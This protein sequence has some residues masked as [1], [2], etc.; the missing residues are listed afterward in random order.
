MNQ[1][2]PSVDQLFHDVTGPVKP[3]VFDQKVARVFDDMVARSI[4]FYGEIL[5]LI[6]DL[7]DVYLKPNFRIFDLGCSTGTTVALLAQHLRQKGLPVSFVA[8]DNSPA[9][10]EECQKKLAHLG[11]TN[12]E[13]RCQDLQA[14][15]WTETP[16]MIIM[17]YTLQFIPP[18]QRS[19][20]LKN[21]YRALAPHGVFILSEKIKSSH[22]AIETAQTKLYY[23]FKKRNGYSELEI[24]KKREALENVLIPQTIEEHLRA[25]AEAG[26]G[27]TEPLFRWYNFASILSLKEKA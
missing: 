19:G 2:S 18:A 25:L 13:L 8:I 1:P 9:M 17:N 15:D 23:D 20:L 7:S 5:Q 6:L 16:N 26:F 12:V 24:A 3:F 11:I 27:Q 4:P 21:I 10:L 14:L 22:S